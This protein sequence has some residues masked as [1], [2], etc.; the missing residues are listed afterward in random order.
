MS[1]GEDY[2]RELKAKIEKLR[3]EDSLEHKFHE[4]WKLGCTAKYKAFELKFLY[5]NSSREFVEK[6]KE[7][8][9]KI[10]EEC[11]EDLE[12]NV[13]KCMKVMKKANNMRVYY[14]KTNEDAHRYFMEELGGT[15]VLFKS[16]SNEAKDIGLIEFLEEEGIELIETDMGDIILELMEYDHPTYQLGPGAHF[17]EEEIVQKIKEKHGVELEPNA[18]AI[19]DYYRENFRKELLN[20]VKISLTS[21]NAISADD[22]T[23]FLGENEGN[24][25]LLTRAVDTHIVVCGITKIVPTIIDALIITKIQERINNV[26]F[27]YISLI[28]GPSN[29]SDIQGKQVQGMYGAKEV[30]VIFVDD[31]RIRAKEEDMPYKD[32]LKCISCKSCIYLC[33]AFRAFGNLYASK[34]GI[35]GPMIIRDYIHNGI[36]AAVKDGLFLCSGCENCTNWCPAGIDLAQII[37]M[38]KKEATDNNLCPLTLKEYQEKI[39]NEKNPFL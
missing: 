31:W 10:R 27:R 24:I 37:R 4:F 26:S 5:E 38:L 11:I 28:S 23:I 15:R 22:G 30:V 8:L 3:N 17:K 9:I 1:M 16:K 34:Y 21:A 33:T 2:Y 19:V 6:Y 13:E 39:I 32:F 14:A 18:Q 25:S 7:Q 12:K 29:T 20:K 36:E 35:G